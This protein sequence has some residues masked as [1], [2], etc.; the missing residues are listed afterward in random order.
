MINK[1][2]NISFKGVYF[3]SNIYDINPE[4]RV[5]VAKTVQKIDDMFPEND[6]FLG[7]NQNG[8]LTVQVQK[9]NPLKYLLDP[10]VMEKLDI[11]FEQLV[12]LLNFNS[13]SKS[14]NDFIWDKKRPIA[15]EQIENVENLDID[16]LAAKIQ[17]TVS[18][19]NQKN[20]DFKI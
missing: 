5:K 18:M 3:L 10:D 4:N 6:V 12:A 8:D 9:T 20:K 7:A 17:D 1:L 15:F 14:L 13:A 19:F 11:S 2:N 16:D